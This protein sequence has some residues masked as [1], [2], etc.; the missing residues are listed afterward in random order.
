MAMAGKSIPMQ[1]SF[2]STSVAA[3]CSPPLGIVDRATFAVGLFVHEAHYD[4]A[5]QSLHAADYL[6]LCADF[7]I[8]DG[9]QT[10][11][12]QGRDAMIG[13]AL[14]R[15]AKDGRTTQEQRDLFGEIA[16]HART[17]VRLQQA[18]ERQ[19][20]ALLAGTFEAMDRACWLIDA[21]VRRPRTRYD[22]PPPAAAPSPSP[23]AR[24]SSK[25]TDAP[26]VA[27]S[28]AHESVSHEAR[29]SWRR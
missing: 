27:T 29:S 21:A 26:V 2:S 1:W 7:D 19:G 8:F 18:V 12:H 5:R 23:T 22:A 16:D 20:F 6:D 15:S 28:K 3:F 4:I 9:C 25:E 11:L 13:L 10:R 17:A 24:W 14:L